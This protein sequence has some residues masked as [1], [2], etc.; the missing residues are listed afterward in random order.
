M[1]YALLTPDYTGRNPDYKTG[2]ELHDFGSNLTRRILTP[3]K[4]VFYIDSL[5]VVEESTGRELVPGVDFEWTELVPPVVRESGLMAVKG[6]VIHNHV[7]NPL[8]VVEYQYVGGYFNQLGE[9]QAHVQEIIDSQQTVVDYSDIVGIPPDGLP[10]TDHQH[11]E[12]NTF[13]WWGVV[14]AL[15]RLAYALE[16]RHH[17]THEVFLNKIAR[18]R[19]A[20]NVDFTVIAT[21]LDQHSA[22]RGAIHQETPASLSIYTKQEVNDIVDLYHDKLDTVDNSDRLVG[23]E[24]EIV[25]QLAHYLVPPAAFDRGLVNP[26]VLAALPADADV[27]KY[28]L[29]SQGWI[30]PENLALSTDTIYMGFSDQSSVIAALAD[31]PVGT[32]AS[33]LITYSHYQDW[34]NGGVNY[35]YTQRREVIKKVGLPNS[36][37]MAGG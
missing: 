29:T 33:Y 32:R 15:D 17:S 31:A 5:K 13:N 11:G 23:D 27:E 37:T 7:A 6:I 22:E 1:D 28:V 34:G 10:P 18:I 8:R 30:K 16:V 9:I 26:A 36:W 2:N 24:Y 12:K 4:G 14:E 3:A 35:G 25:R 20:M 19:E 21:A